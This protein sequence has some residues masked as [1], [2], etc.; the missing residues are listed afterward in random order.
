VLVRFVPWIDENIKGT[1]SQSPLALA[2]L[3]PMGFRVRQ[4]ERMC[5]QVIDKRL[6]NACANALVIPHGNA[7]LFQQLWRKIK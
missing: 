7:V 6:Y 2:L 1:R 4:R 5:I 3:P